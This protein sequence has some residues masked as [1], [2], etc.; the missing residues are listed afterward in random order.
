MR[1]DTLLSP[2]GLA[3]PPFPPVPLPSPRALCYSISA[4][5]RA[6]VGCRVGVLGLA[7]RSALLWPGNDSGAALVVQ[8]AV[9][10]HCLIRG[11]GEAG[12]PYPYPLIPLPSALMDLLP[13]SAP[14]V[15]SYLFLALA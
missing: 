8:Q 6:Y 3:L 15:T 11:G 14:T 1:Q 5:A 2:S 12:S 7:G 13:W 10:D 4:S 9:W